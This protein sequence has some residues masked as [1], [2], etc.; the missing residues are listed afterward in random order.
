MQAPGHDGLTR[1]VG[2]RTGTLAADVSWTGCVQPETRRGTW[3]DSATG[4]TRPWQAIWLPVTARRAQAWPGSAVTGA[5]GG[6]AGGPG[7]GQG[8]ARDGLG[9]AGRSSPEPKGDR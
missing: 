7:P 2:A 6:G 8:P 3:R 9:T 4:L 5:P 1:A